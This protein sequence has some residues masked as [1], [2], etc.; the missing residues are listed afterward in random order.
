MKLI[1]SGESK[2]V[3]DGITITELIK[4]ENVK[5]PTYVTVSVNTKFPK[6]TEYDS[7]VLK[8]GDEVEFLYYMGG[9]K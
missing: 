9:G 4:E 3:R 2:E 5:Y 1:I 8:D 7:Y 6:S